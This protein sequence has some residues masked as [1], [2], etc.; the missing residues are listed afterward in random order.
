MSRRHYV[1]FNEFD[2]TG[3]ETALPNGI[4]DYNHEKKWIDLKT[5]K[6]NTISHRD[7]NGLSIAFLENAHKIVFY[8]QQFPKPGTFFFFNRQKYEHKSTFSIKSRFRL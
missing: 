4:A 5:E 7:R 2:F 1:N 8:Y 6:N 3:R